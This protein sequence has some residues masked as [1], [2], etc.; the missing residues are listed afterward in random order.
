MATGNGERRKSQRVRVG[1]GQAPPADVEGRTITEVGV[2][3]HVV[4]RQRAVADRLSRAEAV[5]TF[6]DFE[7]EE[8]LLGRR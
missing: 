2:R 1:T 8:R 7:A 3:Q 5:P 4:R 6:D